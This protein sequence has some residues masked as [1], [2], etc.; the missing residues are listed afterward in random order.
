MIM[1]MCANA[2]TNTSARHSLPLTQLYRLST[3]STG[4][5]RLIPF[6]SAGGFMFSGISSKAEDFEAEA[7]PHVNGL[8][9]TAVRLATNR[10]E[11]EDLV[12]EVYLQAWKSFHRFE[13]GT[14][15]R[16]WLFKILMNKT[17]KR[18]RKWFVL[19]KENSDTIGDV[20]YIA[21]VSEHLSDEQII[22]SLQKI[23][24][25][26]REVILL[27]DVEGFSYKETADILN[28]PIGTVMSRLNRGRKMLRIELAEVAVSYG[29]NTREI[30]Q[31]SGQA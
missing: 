15:C 13:V 21:P 18:S 28:V 25:Y 1:N 7:L 26:F 24:C 29:I 10:A 6:S 9:R 3:H 2:Q 20:T 4:V 17:M 5:F 16:A 12:Q 22:S 27:T 23:P 14:N 30:M 31:V 19:V 8:F 11:A